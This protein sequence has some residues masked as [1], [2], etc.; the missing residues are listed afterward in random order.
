[1]VNN[2]TIQPI[3]A[4]IIAISC[5]SL[6]YLIHISLENTIQNNSS[7]MQKQTIMTVLPSADNS[8]ADFDEIELE[9]SVCNINDKKLQ[10]I[11]KWEQQTIIGFVIYPCIARGYIDNIHLSIGINTQGEIHKVVVLQQNETK[12]LGDRIHQKYSDWLIQFQGKSVQPGKINDWEFIEDGGTINALSGATITS[13]AVTNAIR[14]SLI[15]YGNEN[16]MFYSYK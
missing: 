5:C 14:D 15:F 3:I 10:L 8:E 9:T 4:S 12:N 2:Q 6:L 16:K 7:S 11:R 13:R 1:M